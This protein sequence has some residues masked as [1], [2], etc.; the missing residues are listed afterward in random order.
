[1]PDESPPDEPPLC[2]EDSLLVD[3]ALALCDETPAPVARIVAVA[4]RHRSGSA[5]VLREAV[6][7]TGRAEV[8]RLE[9]RL[10]MLA[11]IAQ[12]APLLGLLGTILGMARLAI[13]F[14]G[15]VLVT[16]GDLLG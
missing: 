1:M 9:R 5:R 8:S 4:V 16:R 7:T 2:C 3:E 14:N 6:D 12:A 10:A 13:S 11:I 15:H